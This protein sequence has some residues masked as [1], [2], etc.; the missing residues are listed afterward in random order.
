MGENFDDFLLDIKLDY[1]WVNHLENYIEFVDQ[2]IYMQT[3]EGF[4][5]VLKRS[6]RKKAETRMDKIF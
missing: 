5:S 4:Q 3:I 6:L 1:D 2:N